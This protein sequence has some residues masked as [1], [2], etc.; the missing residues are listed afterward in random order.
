MACGNAGRYANR[1]NLLSQHGR[2]LLSKE[3]AVAILDRIIETVRNAW[4][5]T[6]RRAGV[7][8]SDCEAIAGAFL[9]AGFFYSNEY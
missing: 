9:Y 3:E 8:E 7:S 4:R 6:M 1:E 2:F 5:P